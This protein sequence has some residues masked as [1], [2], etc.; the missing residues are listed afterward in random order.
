MFGAPTWTTPLPS[1]S[2]ITAPLGITTR[3]DREI[4]VLSVV[5]SIKGL[6]GEVRINRY[7]DPERQT[8]LASIRNGQFVT[9]D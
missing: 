7:G 2:L 9:I 4:T 5:T 8:F 3:Q 1:A 6:Q